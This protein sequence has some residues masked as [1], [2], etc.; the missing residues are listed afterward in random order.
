MAI[1]T[2]KVKVIPKSLP[3]KGQSQHLDVEIPGPNGTYDYDNAG[4]YD[5]SDEN[6]ASVRVMRGGT[7]LASFSCTYQTS[8]SS[9]SLIELSN[10]EYGGGGIGMKVLAINTLFDTLINKFST[11]SSTR[12]F[13][14]TL[15]DDATG[16]LIAEALQK[17]NSF[18]LVKSFKNAN[19]G[20]V[21][22]L[23][24]SNNY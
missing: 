22:H 9:C 7:V 18:T 13:I 23:Y 10:F 6:H 4:S 14:F 3:L 20:N 2:N 1:K 11:H 19:S 8:P 15:L 17:S 16:K 21:N 24:I 12:T 5:E